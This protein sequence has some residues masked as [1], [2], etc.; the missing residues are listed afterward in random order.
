MKSGD[1]TKKVITS[2]LKVDGVEYG[3]ETTQDKDGRLLSLTIPVPSP[4]ELKERAKAREQFIASQP[5]YEQDA[6]AVQLYHDLVEDRIHCSHCFEFT[7]LK[8]V[9]DSL[10]LKVGTRIEY[11]WHDWVRGDHVWSARGPISEIWD[12]EYIDPPKPLKSFLLD[13]FERVY[14]GEKTDL[15][16]ANIKL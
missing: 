3:F 12:D 4:E 11:R 7:L 14:V 15:E 1:D 8:E 5:L 10:D 6:T 16:E 13:E 2:K 9:F